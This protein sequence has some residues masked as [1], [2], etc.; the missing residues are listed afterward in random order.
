MR[1]FRL[2]H[3]DLAFHLDVTIY[4]R[5]GR[6]MTTANRN[7]DSRGRSGSATHPKRP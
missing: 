2:S 6:F 3:S 1:H 7:E 4:E 5:D